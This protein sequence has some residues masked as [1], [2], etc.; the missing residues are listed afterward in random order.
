MRSARVLVLLASLLGVG[1]CPAQAGDDAAAVDARPDSATGRIVVSVPTDA[2]LSLSRI[3]DKEVV[4]FSRP[5]RLVQTP[6]PPGPGIVAV[7]SAGDRLV[8]HLVAGSLVKTKRT[9][10]DVVLQVFPPSPAP[11][12]AAAEPASA[13]PVPGL[14]LP[15]LPTPLVAVVDKPAHAKMPVAPGVEDHQEPAAVQGPATDASGPVSVVASIIAAHADASDGDLLL[16]FARSVGAAAYVRGST[17]FVVFD[18]SKPVDLSGVVQNPTFG[19][20]AFSLLATGAVLTL[21]VPPGTMPGVQ[22]EQ[23]GWRVTMK[24]GSTPPQ[25]IVPVVD[26]D[27][28]RLPVKEPG[29]V[30]V[31]PDPA[32]GT[33]ILVGT[34][35][36]DGQALRPA[37]RGVDYTLGTTILGVAVE[38]ISDALELRPMAGGFILDVPPG[39]GSRSLAR[40]RP[41]GDFSRI[42]D[43][44]N[45][46]EA[47]LARRFRSAL[48]TAASLPSAARRPARLDA[49]EAALGLG[50]GREAGE[51]AAIADQDN[52]GAADAIRSRFLQAAASL[53]VDSSAAADRLADPDI[54]NS[55]EAT[56][57]R[58]LELAHR[59]P[60]NAEAAHVIAER[61][62]LLQSYPNKLRRQLTGTAALCLVSGGSPAEAKQAAGLEGEGMVALAKALLTERSQPGAQAFAQMGKLAFDRDPQVAERA[63]EDAVSIGLKN[64]LIDPGKAADRLEAQVLNARMTGVELP[65]R[66]RVA[67]LRAQQHDWRP[68]LSALRDIEAEFPDAAVEARRRAGTILKLVA[69]DT[70]AV[71]DAASPGGGL[72][73]QLS[74]L[75]DN[76]DLLPPG[77]QGDE[78][79][80]AIA[81]RLAALDLPDQA[82][83]LIQAA[84]ARSQAGIGRAKLGM[85]LAQLRTDQNNIPAAITALDSTGTGDLPDDLVAARALVRARADAAGGDAAG[86][87]ETLRPLHGPDVEELRARVAASLRDW[88]TE[89][90]A[91][92]S[93]AA[94]R[95]PPTGPVDG[96]GADLILRLAGA[97]A[98][99]DHPDQVRQL[100]QLW[101]AR[102]QDPG[103]RSMLHL[104]ASPSVS[105]L[106]ELAQ[107]A[108]DLTVARTAVAAVTQPAAR[109][110]G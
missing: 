71:A 105:A 67:D 31:V 13:E 17:L 25:V 79:S 60:D 107:S 28:V 101:S 97:S 7:S 15:G 100:D 96:A 5:F 104:L 38:R 49:A 108:K 73:A 26:D 50:R 106:S 99:A 102:I 57:W 39:L 82:A 40:M 70:S 65:V 78:V 14:V 20:A 52:P 103:K 8:V 61:L 43:L 12:L 42:L 27:A 37:R 62:P 88:N 32:S 22:Q 11:R 90:T 87:I 29:H 63:A 53:L 83:T 74:L 34:T 18:S 6:G 58:A 84:V 44:P 110:G 56:L 33:N 24:V 51:L 80:V 66:F 91:L 35:R 92:T 77:D 21:P 2:T 55:D 48:A 68:A 1:I 16:P 19:H 10:R 64:H 81:A 47:E 89:A 72:I 4:R 41:S 30:V 93:L 9:G 109:S 95:L 59:H 85:E 36:L 46:D 3:G 54:G 75:K 23:R 45:I 98:R 94:I 69:S 76:L 86:A